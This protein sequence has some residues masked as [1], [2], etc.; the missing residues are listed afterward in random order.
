M[1]VNHGCYW[2]FANGKVGR[3]DTLVAD[4]SWKLWRRTY[5][6]DIEKQIWNLANAISQSKPLKVLCIID[7]PDSDIVKKLNK[8]FE[9][10]ENQFTDNFS[11]TVICPE[12]SS[13]LDEMASEYDEAKRLNF[14]LNQLLNGFLQFS[15]VPDVAK[16]CT[17]PS[18]TGTP[19]SIEPK[20]L[21]WLEEELEIVH[22][23]SGYENDAKNISPL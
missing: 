15:S 2:Y 8:V 10:I 7:T 9:R 17:L 6:N 1:Y 12:Q 23:K 22:S 3:D 21:L 11:S 19:V 18:R 5:P 20:D 13:E 4:N 16:D 14:P